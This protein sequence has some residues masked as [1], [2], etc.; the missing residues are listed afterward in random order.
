MTA[1]DVKET[2]PLKV[3]D[4]D[5]LT[6]DG[7]HYDEVE[8]HWW[9]LPRK[10]IFIS[11]FFGLLAFLELVLA[12]VANHPFGIAMAILVI[13]VISLS[14]LRRKFFFYNSISRMATFL[15]VFWLIYVMIL[16]CIRFASLRSY[17]K[18]DV[19]PERC[20]IS[21]SGCTRL[22][23]K[24]HRAEILSVPDLPYPKEHVREQVAQ[25]LAKQP[26]MRVRTATSSYFHATRVSTFL[27]FTD[28]LAILLFCDVS[29]SYPNFLTTTHVWAQGELRIGYSDGGSN[30]RVVASLVNYLNAPQAFSEKPKASCTPN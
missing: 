9:V 28:D 10:E 27:G 6:E 16:V 26:R 4:E 8:K 5:M 22:A 11:V 3:P 1:V 23:A 30:Y 24:S 12:S 15:R 29:S 18:Y 2:H 17:H 13:P 25:W 21:M 14:C 7:E 20:Y 19:F